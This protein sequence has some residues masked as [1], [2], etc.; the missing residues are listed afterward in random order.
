VTG[1]LA[2]TLGGRTV[3]GMGALLLL[4]AGGVAAVAGAS[5][6]GIVVAGTPREPH[7]AAGSPRCRLPPG[8]VNRSPGDVYSVLTERYRQGQGRSRIFKRSRKSVIV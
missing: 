6:V 7:V 2:D 8:G 3:S 4:G 5:R 1:R